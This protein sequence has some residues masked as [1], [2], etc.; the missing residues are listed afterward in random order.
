MLIEYDHRSF[1]EWVRGKRVIVVGPAPYLLEPSWADWGAVIDSYDIVVRIKNG[2]LLE[3]R[4]WPHLGR[5]CDV[6]YTN[7]DG[8]TTVLTPETVKKLAAMGCRYIVNPQPQTDRDRRLYISPNF[9]RHHEDFMK[10]LP[11]LGAEQIPIRV[12][13]NRSL[14]N[15]EKLAR[16]LKAR[17]TILPMAIEDLRSAGASEICLTGFS[18]R[19]SWDPPRPPSVSSSRSRKHRASQVADAFG[20]PGKTRVFPDA[21]DVP[22][23][24]PAAYQDFYKS[25][26]QEENSHRNVGRVHNIQGEFEYAKKRLSKNDI[27]ADRFIRQ[28]LV[29]TP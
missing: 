25:S 7:M 21:R 13:F 19:L 15:Y 2:F 6:L 5:R 24:T 20:V 14:N 16:R 17:P 11:R 4:H 8:S 10:K 28:L 1:R 12:R 27:S 22:G 18:F 26:R 9:R 29:G 23:K 3:E